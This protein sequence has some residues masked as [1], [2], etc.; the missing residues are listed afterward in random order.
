MVKMLLLRT[1]LY[2]IIIMEIIAEIRKQLKLLSDTESKVSFQRWFKEPII[3]YGVKSALIKKLAKDTFKSIKHLDKQ[4]IFNLCESLFQS[5][6]CEE[7][8]IACNR[9]YALRKQYQPEDFQIFKNWSEKYINNRAKCDTFCN[10]TLGEF[11]Q[12]YPQYIQD[13]KQRTTSSNRRVKRAAAVTFI[14]PARK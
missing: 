7:A 5:D 2:H 6:Y 3:A 9:S 1:Y 12:Q 11:I 13:L 4:S 14:I 10:H 8:F